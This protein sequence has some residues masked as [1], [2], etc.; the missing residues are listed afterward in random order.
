VPSTEVATLS[1][2]VGCTQNEDMTRTD[3]EVA[4]IGFGP[5]G[6]ALAGLLG[7][8]GVRVTVIERDFDVYPL[9]RAAHIDHQSLRLL[10]ELGCLEELLP[11]MSPN[12][13]VDFVTA[14]PQLRMRIPGNLPSV[15][16]LPAS[17]YFHQP[18]VDRARGRVAAALPSVEGKLGTRRVALEAREDH[19]V[20]HTQDTEGVEGRVT[21]D[22]VV[23][24]DGAWSPVR[25]S[26]EIALKS[27]NFDEKWFVVD[28]K[29]KHPVATLPD[30]AV[31]V[32]DPRQTQ[33]AFPIPDG[34][35]R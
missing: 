21:A 18:P 28:L 29:L 15:S 34:R 13:G 35:F 20:I 22:W 5:V 16:G 10:Q 23:G 9:P 31:T 24:C 6:A 25:E 30:R 27:L 1:P 11:R 3:A 2:E 19:A 33:F 17:M 14:V 32:C 4:I 8:R 7:R 26:V 12:P